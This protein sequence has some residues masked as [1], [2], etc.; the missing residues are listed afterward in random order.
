[1]PAAADAQESPAADKE[2]L[3]ALGKR[4]GDERADKDERLRTASALARALKTFGDKPSLPNAPKIPVLE[5]LIK[6][7]RPVYE[8]ENPDVRA[9]AAMLL[10]RLHLQAHAVFKPDETAQGRAVQIYRDAHPAANN[11]AE[12]IVIYPTNR[13][14]R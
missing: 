13:L 14:V 1:M 4:F 2:S 5:A 7:C 12:A 9:A 11:A 3:L 10:G 8:S 6:Q